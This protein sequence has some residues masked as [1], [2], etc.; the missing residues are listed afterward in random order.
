MLPLPTQARPPLLPSSLAERPA[1]AGGV[2]PP[3]RNGD[4]TRKNKAPAR[5]SRPRLNARSF[6]GEVLRIRL[7]PLLKG[8]MP[9][10]R[11][12]SPSGDSTESTPREVGRPPTAGGVSWRAVILGVVLIP[13]ACWWLEYTECVSEGTDM[14]GISYV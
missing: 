6:K 5:A 14:A 13:P 11:T 1:L 2:R 12:L 9:I 10:S 4:R 3:A 8:Y 7:S